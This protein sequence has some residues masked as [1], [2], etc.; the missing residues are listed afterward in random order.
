M[1]FGYKRGGDFMKQNKI[2]KGLSLILTFALVIGLLP[3]M[4]GNANVVKAAG[5]SA[6]SITAYATKDELMNWAYDTTV[7]KI[8]FGK[9]SS[10]NPLEWYI[11]GSDSGV[12]GDNTAIFATSPI[13]TNVMFEDDSDNYKT[14]QESFGTYQNNTPTEVY[15]NHYGASDLRATLNEMASSNS[16]FT[17]TEQSLLQNTTVTTT[18]TKSSTP[19]TTTDVLYALYSERDNTTLYAGSDNGKA[20]AMSTYWNTGDWFWLRA[21][22]DSIDFYALVAYPGNYVDHYLVSFYGAVQPASNLNLS[23]AIFASA[24]PAASSDTVEAGTI[25]TD[26]AMTLRLDGSGMNIGNVIYD[27]AK[28]EKI[29]VNKS[30]EATGTVSVVVQGNDGTNDWYYTKALAYGEI[31]EMD[32]IKTALNLS[33]DIAVNDCKIWL[34][35]IVDG[36]TYAKTL[37]AGSYTEVGEVEI[38]IDEPE[39]EVELALTGETATSG[40]ATTSPSISW[41]PEGLDGGV[42]DYDTAYT[43]SFTLEETDESLFMSGV[44]ATVNG[45]SATVTENGDGTITV[46]Y[47]FPATIKQGT[48]T[49]SIENSRFGEDYAVQPESDTND[50]T[51]FT[52]EYKVKDASDDTYTDVKPTAVGDYTARVTMPANAEYSQVVLTADFSILKADG[53]V[54]FSIDNIKYGGTLVPQIA[55][56]TNDE[57]SAVIEYKI[58][59]ASED[60]YSTVVPTAVGSYMARVTLPTN[61][62]YEEVQTTASFSILKA[63]GTATFSIA[64][65]NYGGTLVPQIASETNDEESAVIEYKIAAAVEDAYSTVVPTAV[66]SYTARVTLP[67][68]ESYEEVVKTTSFSILKTAGTGTFSIA[69]IRYGETLVPQIASETNEI[70]SAIVEYKLAGAEDTAYSETVPTA[71]GSYTARVTLPS[72]ISYEKVVK[73]TNFSILKADGIADF[74]I[75]D[76]YYG[77]LIEPKIKTSTNDKDNVVVEYKLAGAVDDAYSATVP[78]AVGSYTARVILPENESYEEV[79]LTTSFSILKAEG[80]GTFSIAD[81]YYGGT[82][83]PQ[84]ASQTNDAS[85]A[86]Y[87]YKLAG[88]E[89]ATYSATVPTEV[90]SYTARVTIPENESYNSVVLTDGFTISYLPAPDSDIDVS[91]TS[92][93]NEYYTSPVTVEPPEG[94]LISDTLDGEYSTS[95]VLSESREAGYFYLLNIATGEKTAGIWSDGFLIDIV[96]P[97]IDAEEGKTYYTEFKEVTIEDK[98]LSKITINGEEFKD[99]KDGIAKIK[100]SSENGVKVY[101]I[102]ITDLAGNEKKLKFIVASEWVK[103]GVVPTGESVSL[104]SDY[105]Y[106]LGEGSWQLEG[107]ATSYNGNITF[108]VVEEGEYVFSQQ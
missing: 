40:V 28:G 74:K 24:A 56:E 14:Y 99:F 63:E 70:E 67:T 86:F 25:Q 5:G 78:T 57:E 10:G 60:A 21:P 49:L 59:A 66:G 20:L 1:F 33:D 77:G 41:T 15:P 71:V 45:E 2:K 7:G 17:G 23:S 62:S 58:A 39:A 81:I 101:E 95:L 18:D 79:V 52:A 51:I 47:T 84:V 97:S 94:Y 69:D 75:E 87:E 103:K 50:A 88:A 11:L 106:K 4:P 35:T 98:N 31:I 92:G 89:D 19:Y 65:I 48:G 55:S 104:I 12:A 64:D 42:A 85:A 54:T 83:S 22:S 34:E 44:T 68:N 43:A 93:T 73:T 61:E 3:V 102:V 82:V 100:L 96:A 72:N 38:A 8:V 46:S 27:S 36:V 80:T 26:K 13:A 53:A 32:E 6:P 105:E 108:Y 37:T 30:S 107:D 9:D 76:I 90:G 16:Y 91:G 29:Y